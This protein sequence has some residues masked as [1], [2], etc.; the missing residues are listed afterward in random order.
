MRIS[1]WS[2]DVCSSDLVEVE[3]VGE[4]VL[5]V[6]VLG[7]GGVDRGGQFGMGGGELR[8]GRVVQAGGAAL[9]LVGAERGELVDEGGGLRHRAGPPFS[10]GAGAAGAGSVARPSI[11]DIFSSVIRCDLRRIH[12]D[13][14][15]STNLELHP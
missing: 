2:S 13:F 14:G 8:Q 7:G 15:K 6:R 3:Q 9:A 4:G 10:S 12:V 5:D 11:I 1:D